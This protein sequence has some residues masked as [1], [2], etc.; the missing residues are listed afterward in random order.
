MTGIASTMEHPIGTYGLFELRIGHGDVRLRGVDGTVV[1]VR[2]RLGHDLSEL[3]RIERGEGSLSL[4]TPG[5]D[6]RSLVGGPWR[7]SP[8]LDVEVPAKATIV[9][10]TGSAEVDAEGLV[11]SQSFR[12][13]SGDVTLRGAG[14]AIAVDAVSGEVEVTAVAPSKL[15][16]RTVSGD[17][18][19]RAGTIEGL[20]AATTSGDIRVAGRLDDAG[21]FA[22][23]TVSGDA[24]L[25]PASG[26]RIEAASVTGDIRSDLEA[27][28]QRDGGRQAIE[29][30][31]GGP[32]VSFRS[33]SGDLR[34]VRAEPL[35]D[36]AHRV[37]S[38]DPSV[39]QPTVVDGGADDRLDILRALE[40]GDIDVAEARSRL[41]ALDASV[42]AG[43]EHD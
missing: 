32:T 10:E 43:H 8:E 23:E 19:I 42:P 31:S 36:D 25:A 20:E 27:H 35:G 12:T 34:V 11:G 40:R 7:R 22:I 26:V 1:R 39:E 28:I 5:P 24:I 6:V 14:G 3:F 38:S 33:M 21:F 37:P 2:D 13:A 18:A 41:E 9:V 30:G 4:Q 16:I 15:T 29:V 17:V